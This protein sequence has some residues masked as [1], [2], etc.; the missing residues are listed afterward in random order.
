LEEATFPV[1]KGGYDRRVINN[2]ETAVR[3]VLVT[4][5]TS[6]IGQA[7]AIELARLGFEVVGSAMDKKGAAD[8]SRAASAA[9]ITLTSEILEL[10]DP[11]SYS[12][13][14]AD[15]DLWAVVNNAGYPNAG[16]I[17]DI[18]PD[19]ARRQLEDIVLAPAIITL[20]A[21]PAMRRRRSGRVVKH[22]SVMVGTGGPPPG[23]HQAAKHA[24]AGLGGALR[25]ELISSGVAVVSI[26]PSTI[27][28]P[29]WDRTYRDLQAKYRGSAHRH[30]YEQA[31]SIIESLRRYMRSPEAVAAV[32]GRALTA[33]KPRARYQVGIDAWLLHTGRRLLPRPSI[34]RVSR[35]VVGV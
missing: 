17:E 35:R 32:V 26:D 22:R 11:S 34:D 6:G 28:T 15:L 21:P 1:E 5:A 16:A 14:V 23:W 9:A 29:I 31:M 3:R 27:D 10:S 19:E 33:G 7:T 25:N 24:L 8:L 18:S 4:G 2:Q 12:D 13:V 20:P 30:A